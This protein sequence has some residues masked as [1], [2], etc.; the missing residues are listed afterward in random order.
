M[1]PGGQVYIWC[2]HC[3]RMAKFVIN[4]SGAIWWSNLQPIQE[5]S[6]KSISNYSRWEIYSSCEI[7]TL[8]PLCLWQCFLQQILSTGWQN[9]SGEKPGWSELQDWDD[10]WK[11]TLQVN[12]SWSG[13][14][15]W[16]S[17]IHNHPPTTS[18][19]FKLS[20]MTKTREIRERES[21]L[22]FLLKY[23][24]DNN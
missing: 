5:V 18:W 19:S 3:H 17:N 21:M 2:K 8:G 6:L 1:P 14:W 16:S 13:P 11:S 7:N 4:S 22:C 24:N 9:L 20:P 12:K 10:F 15:W 23:Q